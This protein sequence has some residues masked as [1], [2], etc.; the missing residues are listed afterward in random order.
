MM[1]VVEWYV[2]VVEWFSVDMEMVR[3]SVLYIDYYDSI[4]SVNE[5]SYA[6]NAVEC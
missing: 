5:F 1:V 3:D 4:L 2:M 6:I